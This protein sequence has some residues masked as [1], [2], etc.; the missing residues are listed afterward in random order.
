MKQGYPTYS[1][2]ARTGNDGIDLVSRVVH[3]ELGWL[4][5]RNHQEHDFGIDAQVDLI[6]DDGSVTGQIIAMQIKYG[7]S[8]FQEKNQ[9]GYVYR[10]EQKH[11]NYLANYPTPV[12]IVIC[13]PSSHVCYWVEF[14]PTETSRAGKNWNITIPY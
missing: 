9:W 4:F 6:L 3:E 1:K 8:F 12:L 7:K 10:G 13:N 11:F 2:A 5:K 14:D